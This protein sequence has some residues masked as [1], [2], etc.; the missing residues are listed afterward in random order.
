[1]GSA[2]LP[3]P[4]AAAAGLPS[5]I[6]AALAT[7]CSCSA[8]VKHLESW[9]GSGASKLITWVG[10]RLAMGLCLFSRS[11]LAAALPCADLQEHTQCMSIAVICLHSC[12]IDIEAEDSV[13]HSA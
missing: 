12:S 4:A 5:A 3:L 7:A 2:G 9:A 1:M 13:D 6:A 8:T 10:N 11:G